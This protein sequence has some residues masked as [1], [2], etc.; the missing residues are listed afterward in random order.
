[1]EK[2]SAVDLWKEEKMRWTCT[3]L[4]VCFAKRSYERQVIQRY[5]VDT[6][7]GYVSRVMANIRK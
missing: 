4:A 2:S 1:M 7:Q 6:K 3:G 5:G